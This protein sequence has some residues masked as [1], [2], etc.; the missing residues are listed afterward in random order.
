LIGAVVLAAG[1]SSRM[2][3][4]KAAMTVGREGPSFLEAILATLDAAG[5]A[6]VRVV[7]R[8]GEAREAV[9]DVVNPNPTAG[10]LS[11]VQCGIRALPPGLAAVFVWPVDHPLVDKATVLAMIAA[12][13]TGGAPIV[14]PACDGRRGHPVLVSAR[15]LP[16]LFTVD[17]SLGAAAVVH[18]HADRVELAVE[19]R[20]VLSDVD[21]PG[22]YERLVA[23]R[24][25]T[26]RE[27]E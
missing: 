19:D 6:V 16:E 15:V 27:A 12:F 14:V 8:P 25:P 26:K 11:S 13:R 1:A 18:A 3:R 9:R 2:G 22:D 10:M 21:T 24:S 23:E 5:V 7:V 17:A 20:G 4:P